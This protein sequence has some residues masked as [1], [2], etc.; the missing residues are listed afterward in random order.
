LT[1]S[2]AVPDRPILWKSVFG[3]GRGL[4]GSLRAPTWT[5]ADRAP[6]AVDFNRDVGPRGRPGV[7][8]AFPPQPTGSGRALQS[9]EQ[10]NLHIRIWRLR[11]RHRGLEQQLRQ[12]LKRPVPDALAIQQLKQRKLQVKDELILAEA[13]LAPAT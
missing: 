6:L 10:M 8:K 7:W 5:V 1:P 3:D 12:A 2:P 4:E 11:N 13:R 9:E